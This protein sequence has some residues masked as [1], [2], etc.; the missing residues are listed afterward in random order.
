MLPIVAKRRWFYVFSLCV[1]V[2]GLIVL[3][4]KGL[5]LG[6]D[7][8]GGSTIEVADIES[9]RALELTEEAGIENA[10]VASVD[11]GLQ[12]R[13]STSDASVIERFDELVIENEG[14]VQRTDT[15]GPSVSSTIIRNAALS[16]GALTVAIVIYIA[17]SFRSVPKP[18][19]SFSFGIMAV[20]ALIHDALIVLGAFAVLGWLVGIEIDA[21]F[22]TALLTVIGFSVHDTIVVM[23]R[24]RENLIR[25]PGNVVGEVN[26]SINEVMGRSLNTS[27]VILLVLLALLLF[28]EGSIRSF[29]L[30]LFIG[31]ISGTYSSIFI[32]AP[33]LVSWYLFRQKPAK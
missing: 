16:I 23:D 32:A 33:L 10:S 5:E 4:F 25:R 22:V 19:S 15:V 29:I 27:I 7:F 1:I 2:P 11:S 26:R 24:L 28:A 30:A 14:M 6:I 9:Q 17:W 12:L 20:V 31:M 21:F 8:T 13:T 18:L 3:G